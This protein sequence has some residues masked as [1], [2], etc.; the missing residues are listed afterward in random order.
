[1]PINTAVAERAFDAEQLCAM[2]IAYEKACRSLGLTAT[3]DRLTDI[4][5]DKIIEIA[6]AGET[7][8][9]RLYE[10]V[11]HWASAA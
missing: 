8:P 4:I 1:M 5:A 2:G 3:P 9:T 7:D 10:A 11:M 6:R